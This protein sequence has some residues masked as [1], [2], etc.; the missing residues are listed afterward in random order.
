MS[1]EEHFDN[2]FATYKNCEGKYESMYIFVVNN[3]VIEALIEKVKKM[4]VLVD[5]IQNSSRRGVL[6]SRLGNFMKHLLGIQSE[7]NVK[8]I[9]LV[10][11]DVNEF[12]I[13]PY[14]MD[15][16]SSFSCENF[17]IRYDSKFDLEWL[18]N[19]LLD[20]KYI[21]VLQMKNNSLKHIHLNKTKKRAATEK[22][23]KGMSIQLYIQENIPKGDLCIIH[24]VSSLIKGI[25]STPKMK[26]LNGHKRDDEIALEHEKFSNEQ[27]A[28]LL[29]W[30][31]DRLTDPKEG[32]KIVFG[33]DINKCIGS[34][35]L[36]TL[37]CSS[38]MKKKVFEKIPRDSLIFEIIEVKSFGEDIGK[39]LITD[40][41]GGIGIKFY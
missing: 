31:L 8:S 22:E 18:K 40:F 16:L 36:K 12:S 30:W 21:H 17:L 39:R 23:E 1:E 20:R 32:S 28:T 33:V 4:I 34:K 5:E 35:T 7:T 37:F 25:E 2:E 29:K 13:K 19:L 15:T 26:I 9:Y 3:L 6:K 14:W 24:G 38:E 41:K 11:E 27:N 10:S